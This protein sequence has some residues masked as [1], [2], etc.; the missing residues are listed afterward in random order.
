LE[1]NAADTAEF[2]LFMDALFD[3]LNGHTRVC[4]KSKPLKGA[5][6]LYSG[7][8]QY[9]LECIN[10]LNARTFKFF[11][12]E[13][14]TFCMVPSITNLIHTLKGMHYL[15]E[16]LFKKNFEYVIPRNINQDVWKIFLDASGAMVSEI[17]HQM[18]S[19]DY[20]EG[21]L[22]NLRCFANWRS[23]GWCSTFGI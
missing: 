23:C 14:Q 9:W 7:H 8:Q 12:A 21:A 17:I 18:L 5:V 1:K 13:K 11:N 19:R 6:R 22:D 16:I 3:S 2:L 4:P 15:M 10:T 20:T